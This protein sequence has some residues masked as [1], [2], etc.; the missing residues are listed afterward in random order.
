MYIPNDYYTIPV[1]QDIQDILKII[2]PFGNYLYVVLTQ[3]LN[4]SID[5][6]QT[7]ILVLFTD[8]TTT[9]VYVDDLIIIGNSRFTNKLSDLD[10]VMH[11]L[12]NIRLKLS[13]KKSFWCQDS[14]N[15]LGF[16]LKRKVPRDDHPS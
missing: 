11:L 10:T 13:L 9:H 8:M 3:G 2:L 6:F 5:F 14:I 1:H 4:I 12:K 7:R 15:Y 16:T